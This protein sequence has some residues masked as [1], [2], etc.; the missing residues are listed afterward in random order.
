M[1]AILAIDSNNGLS[2][3]GTIPWN[4]TKDLNFFYKTTKNNIVI[5][6]KNT[7]FS[8]PE[9]RRPLKDR[10]NIILTRTPNLFR[11]ELSNNV[12]FT[13]KENIHTYILQNRHK[14]LTF[15]P[16][17]SSEFKIIIIGGKQVYDQYIPLCDTVWLTLIK[18]N[19]SCDL[20]FDY[21]LE[22]EFKEVS[23][24]EDDDIQIC[25]YIK[26]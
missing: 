22:K 23:S 21:D 16:S 12:I 10:L 4:S 13:N 7:Y 9:K 3:N 14:F 18:E 11:N 6:G 19:H 25:K 17:L 20:F 8:I 2:K 1:E 26:K 24:I 15:C 5:M